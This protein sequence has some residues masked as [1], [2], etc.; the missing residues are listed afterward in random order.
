VP[1]AF[2]ALA[3]SGAVKAADPTKHITVILKGLQGAR[4]G[5]VTYAAPMPAFA[6]QLNDRQIAAIVNYERTSWGNHAPTVTPQAVAKI[7]AQQ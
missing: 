7:R 1:G 4:V 6:S 5:G 2:P 3:G